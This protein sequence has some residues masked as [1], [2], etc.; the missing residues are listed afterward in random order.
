MDVC[1]VVFLLSCCLLVCF[2]FNDLMLFDFVVG[3]V[4]V[5]GGWLGLDVV[6][7]MFDGCC[8]LVWVG[9]LVVWFGWLFVV[10]VIYLS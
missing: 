6:L 4:F 5:F 10:C 1:L 9:L 7:F 3:L 8:V 2:C